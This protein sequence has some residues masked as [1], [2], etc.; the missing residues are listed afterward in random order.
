MRRD[1]RNA[2]SPTLLPPEPLS[3]PSNSPHA[4]PLP[5]GGL[6]KSV[7]SRNFLPISS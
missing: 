2:M 3:A 4:P 5:V 1:I 6:P 7:V